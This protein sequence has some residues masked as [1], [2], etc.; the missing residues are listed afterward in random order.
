MEELCQ[1][2]AGEN[3]A[4]KP[5]HQRATELVPGNVYPTPHAYTAAK[6]KARMLRRGKSGL[7]PCRGPRNKLPST[8]L[9][10]FNLWLGLAQRNNL[11][12]FFHP[13]PSLPR[14]F[15]RR[16]IPGH[17][18]RLLAWYL[19]E[20]ARHSKNQHSIKKY[21]FMG[22][23]KRRTFCSELT[24][25]PGTSREEGEVGACYEGT[26]SSSSSSSETLPAFTGA[27]SRLHPWGK[28]LS[29]GFETRVE[30]SIL[31]K[32][33]LCSLEVAFEQEN[34]HSSQPSLPQ[35]TGSRCLAIKY[36][37]W[38]LCKRVIF[39]YTDWCYFFKF[40]FF[41]NKTHTSTERGGKGGCLRGRKSKAFFFSF[42]FF[43]LYS[44]S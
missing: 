17:P 39:V 13:E 40:F 1:P 44:L 15:Q 41:N 6:Q 26:T 2:L 27:I 28:Q 21:G 8:V 10:D 7:T 9:F 23:R 12:Y 33:C 14:I 34:G 36:K 25:E 43:Q 19:H 18:H 16:V 32:D 37:W 4:T 38:D 5:Q 3:V 30:S 31:P 11:R 42:F 35:V 24:S 22:G 20:H 29:S